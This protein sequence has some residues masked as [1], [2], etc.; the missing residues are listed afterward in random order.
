MVYNRLYLGNSVYEFVRC[1]DGGVRLNRLEYWEQCPPGSLPRLVDSKDFESEE[2]LDSH[3]Q[4]VF[5]VE[6]TQ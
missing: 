1:Y 5:H 3:F 6:V 2:A 4:S